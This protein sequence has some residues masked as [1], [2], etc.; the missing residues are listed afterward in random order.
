MI[1]VRR[2]GGGF[3]PTPNG[4]LITPRRIMPGMNGRSFPRNLPGLQVSRAPAMGPGMPPPPPPPPYSQEQSFHGQTPGM[5]LLTFGIYQ[6]GNT[7]TI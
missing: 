2:V 6:F 7:F 3:N 1:R 5:L 4:S